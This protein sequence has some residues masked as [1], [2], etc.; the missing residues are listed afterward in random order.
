MEPALLH[1]TSGTTMI[2]FNYEIGLE[3][4]AS[5]TLAVQ[6]PAVW[7]STGRRRCYG[8]GAGVCHP[9]ARCVDGYCVCKLGYKG[10]GCA[11]CQRLTDHDGDCFVN[12]DL[13]HEHASCFRR[14]CQ[15]NFDYI[16][17]GI[18]CR[19]LRSNETLLGALIDTTK[20]I[21]SPSSPS[22]FMCLCPK[23]QTGDGI[24]YCGTAAS[25]ETE[26]INGK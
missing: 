2:S 17:D 14:R 26:P 13:C 5:V 8:N 4:P 10:D 21:A 11:S 9:Q 1:R 16:G 3:I 19:P 25:A 15:C 12:P 20:S 22:S 7:T 6:T 24:N 23:G 18:T